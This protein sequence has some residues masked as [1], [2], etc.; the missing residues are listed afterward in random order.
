MKAEKPTKAKIIHNML[1]IIK[2]PIDNDNT[3]HTTVVYIKLPKK[4]K[5]KDPQNFKTTITTQNTSYCYSIK[6]NNNLQSLL[7]H[8]S[9]Q[10]N[11]IRNH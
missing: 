10:K 9:L 2:D 4:Y 11:I 7:K 3:E 8:T 6:Q 1:K 5:K